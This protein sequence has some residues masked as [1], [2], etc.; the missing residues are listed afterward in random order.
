MAE[1]MPVLLPYIGWTVY[2]TILM[3]TGLDE[4]DN[5]NVTIYDDGEEILDCSGV[6]P[7]I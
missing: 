7:E 5:V 4:G 1:G 6:V 3:E 2:L